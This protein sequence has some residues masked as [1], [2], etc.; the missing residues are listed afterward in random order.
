MEENE[1]KI[2]NKNTEKSVIKTKQTEEIQENKEIKDDNKKNQVNR[3]EEIEMEELLKKKIGMRY[4][5]QTKV[6]NRRTM[7]PGGSK[8]NKFIYILS[9][10]KFD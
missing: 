1:E 5:N 10:T 6:I 8:L 2:Y 3:V 9:W 7:Q 4:E